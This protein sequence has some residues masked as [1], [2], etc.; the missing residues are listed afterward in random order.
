MIQKNKR[1]NKRCTI[2]PTRSRPPLLPNHI[3]RAPPKTVCC[4]CHYLHLFHFIEY[5]KEKFCDIS[6][7][8][9]PRRRIFCGVPDGILATFFV[10]VAHRLSF[11]TKCS[12]RRHMAVS[13]ARET[14][15]HV[16]LS[17][18]LT[19]TS[20]IPLICTVVQW[21]DDT[22]AYYR[23]LTKDHVFYALEDNEKRK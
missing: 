14:F 10:G 18:I 11:A 19:G 17:T 16:W 21:M 22:Y 6:R 20:S 8:A 2:K 9:S 3:S 5:K 7:P 13:S 4:G 1:K 23:T 12:K 15:L